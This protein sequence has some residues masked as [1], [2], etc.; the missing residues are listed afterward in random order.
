[1][2][3]PYADKL[4]LSQLSF[5]LPQNS[6]AR[7]KENWPS[8]VDRLQSLAGCPISWRCDM[9]SKRASKLKSSIRKE[10]AK[11]RDL[12]VYSSRGKG[13]AKAR[14]RETRQL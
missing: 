7:G 4:V 3:A 13:Y 10:M 6:G 1:M 11:A 5:Q 14:K 9:I 12:E 2:L 8:E